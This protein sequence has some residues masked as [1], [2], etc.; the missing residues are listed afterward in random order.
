[1]ASASRKN[2]CSPSPQT[3]SPT[4][5]AWLRI[6]ITAACASYV[7]QNVWIHWR[8]AARPVSLR[9]TTGKAS[10]ITA[11]SSRASRSRVLK[12]SSL[13]EKYR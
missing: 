2:S 7:S 10:V 13:F 9:V 3:T 8:S 6:L 12:M 1:M 5:S 4:R 11:M